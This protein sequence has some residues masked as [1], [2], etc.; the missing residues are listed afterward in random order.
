MAGFDAAVLGMVIGEVKTVTLEPA[1]AYGDHHPERVM[2]VPRSALPEGVEPA[3]GME[4]QAQAPN[5]RSW[6]WS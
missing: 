5:G 1:D 2:Q 6:R 4:F 3:A